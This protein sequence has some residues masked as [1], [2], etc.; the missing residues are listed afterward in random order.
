MRFVDDGRL[1]S[2]NNNAEAKLNGIGPE[3][4]LRDALDR[5]PRGT[6]TVTIE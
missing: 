3:A 2:D 1:E 4:Y 6:V 5:S